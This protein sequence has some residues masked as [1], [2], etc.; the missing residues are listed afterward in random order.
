MTGRVLNLDSNL[1]YAAWPT[2]HKGLICSETP[3]KTVQSS[4]SFLVSWKHRNWGQQWVNINPH[5]PDCSCPICRLGPLGMDNT[6]YYESYFSTQC[7]CRMPTLV[8]FRVCNL[9]P[10]SGRSSKS[11]YT[12]TQDCMNLMD[13]MFSTL[14]PVF[15]RHHSSDTWGQIPASLL[16]SSS[17]RY[18]D[19]WFARMLTGEDGWL[20]CTGV[21]GGGDHNTWSRELCGTNWLGLL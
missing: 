2:G 5:P 4:N 14:V 16:T 21:Q 6:P 1:N 13:N 18:F 17:S 12:K 10:I 9:W 19:G 3:E 8:G 7:H 20:V 11:D 15:T